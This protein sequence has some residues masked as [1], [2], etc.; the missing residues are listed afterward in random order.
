VIAN[1][2]ET[3]PLQRFGRVEEFARAA[4]FLSSPAASYITGV[5]L[6]I[7]GGLIEGV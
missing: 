5:A 7:D 2:A 3:I 6:P 4:V 1:D